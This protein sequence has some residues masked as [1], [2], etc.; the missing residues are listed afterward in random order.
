MDVWEG[1]GI[2]TIF[3]ET[4]GASVHYSISIIYESRSGAEPL[5]RIIFATVAGGIGD[6]SVSAGKDLSGNRGGESQAGTQNR[7]AGARIAGQ[8]NSHYIVMM[9]KGWEQEAPLRF[10]NGFLDDLRNRFRLTSKVPLPEMPDFFPTGAEGEMIFQGRNVLHLDNALR[11]Q[12]LFAHLENLRD[13]VQRVADRKI[14]FPDFISGLNGI[15]IPPSWRNEIVNG[16]FEHAAPGT[17]LIPEAK[18]PGLS[19][20]IDRL[21]DMINQDNT[22]G[23]KLSPHLG[24][25]LEEVGRDSTGFKLR[26][27]AAKQLHKDLVQTLEALRGSLLRHGALADALGFMSTLQRLARGAKGRERQTVHLWTEVPTDPRAVLLGETADGGADFA[28][29]VV[30][31]DPLDRE[32]AYLREV[33]GLCATLA[34]PLL[35]QLPGEEFPKA[36]DGEAA[37]SAITALS[38][39]A[40]SVR[41]PDAYFF[42]G[43]VASRVEGENCV[44]RP[45]ALAFLEGLV[46]SR[47][48]VDF[49]THRSM[50][51]G[52]QDLVTEKGQARATD[53]LLDQTQVNALSGMRINRVNGARNRSEASF[54]LLTPW[55]DA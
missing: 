38:A 41:K 28:V 43:G 17:T 16:L 1:K 9:K 15:S 51:L 45:A 39:L 33:A 46:A 35:L 13:L 24:R 19:S 32:P 27:G 7:S 54:P 36:V 26:D 47:E 31:T 53:R 23:S 20:D 6:F 49:Y 4:F 10:H 14:T 12:T 48:N 30:V 8:G 42:A 21:M 50:V 44:F 2:Y 34:C 55:G 25:F 37:S 18:A 5:E 22:G 3:G 11:E 52:D 40:E 29:A